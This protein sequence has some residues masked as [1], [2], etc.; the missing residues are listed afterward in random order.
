MIKT[1][2]KDK[3]RGKNVT[4]CIFGCVFLAAGGVLQSAARLR[5]GF[6]EW[7]ACVVYPVITGTLGRLSGIFPFSLAEAGLCI[8]IFAAAVQLF[9]LIAGKG[10]GWRRTVAFLFAVVS[11]LFFMYTACCGVN[12][13][14][15][16]FS[17]YLGYET[18]KNKKEE[19]EELLEWLSQQVN[20]SWTEIRADSLQELISMGQ[21]GVESMEGLGEEYPQLSGFYPQPKPLVMSWLLSVQQMCG[22]YSPFTVEANYN[23]DM[24][25]YNIPHTIC[26]ELSH[27]R[28]FMREDEANFIGFL[29]CIGSDSAQYRYSGYLMGWIY[30]GNALAGEDWETYVRY[31]NSLREEVDR[32]LRAN[33]E[34]WNRYES[35]VSEAAEAVNDTYLRMNSQSEGVKSYGR[36][37]DLMLA[38]YRE[39]PWAGANQA[40]EGEAFP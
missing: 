6:G 32:D 28:G 17:D 8:L 22:V 1:G 9:R 3:N 11:F 18:G 27:L 34:F 23:R 13:Y 5:A 4:F 16:P 38:W 25:S 21:A 12:Y 20:E 26:H 36:A 15:R 39:K 19:L 30:A 31:R 40:S 37:V 24:V 33:T 14:R 29:A 35:R 2:F 7:Y 10:A